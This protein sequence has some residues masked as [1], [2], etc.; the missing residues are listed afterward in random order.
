MFSLEKFDKLSRAPIT[1]KTVSLE[2]IGG[3]G[4][5]ISSW[6]GLLSKMDKHMQY[7][8][9]TRV[10]GELIIADVEESVRFGILEKVVPYVERLIANMQLDYVSNP[11][12]PACEQKMCIEEVRSLYFLL[13]LSYQSIAF[14]LHKILTHEASLLPPKNI[15]WLKKMTGG[16]SAN[17]AR[18]GVGVDLVSESKKLYTLSVYRIM[19]SCYRL[20]SEFALTYQKS[21]ISLWR[22]MN[23]WYLKSAALELDKFNISKLGDYADC[24]IHKQYLY[25]CLASFA[26]LFAYRRADI[27]N[28]FKLVPQWSDCVETSF[29]AESHHRL[30][31]NLQSDT[32]PE[33]ITPFASVNPYSD[34]RVCLFFDVRKLFGYL[35]NLET[36][37]ETKHSFEGRLAK[38]ILLAFNRQFEQSDSKPTDRSAYMMTGFGAIYKEIAGGR[39]FNQI[40][41]QSKL[42]S[43]YHP[44]RVFDGQLSAEKE[45]VQLIR[46]NESVTQFIVGGFAN[47]NENQIA[48]RPYLPVFGVFAMMSPRSDNKHPWRLGIVHWA[49][50]NNN[51]VEVD[52]R[53]LGRILSV[54]GIRLNSRDGRG[55]DFV[56]A[57]LVSGDELDE[58]TT[59]VLP[60][61]HFKEGDVVVLRVEDKETTLRLEKAVLA[62]DNLEQ[63]QIVRLS[64]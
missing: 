37:D 32:A 64:A 56:Q 17:I 35:N 51:H 24:S 46:R 41:A 15:S 14:A 21:P 63:Y 52:G 57:F 42:H 43:D 55:Q 45:L 58:Q 11:K 9:T 40:I 34:E 19:V 44:K 48:S 10:L 61:Y 22:L 39:S 5:K 23:G 33:M 50:P 12:C 3:S 29:E 2:A 20:M 62:T 27:I 26:N 6:L 53:F 8:E 28:I 7:R 16:L 13:I 4:E 38:I 36:N 31:V 47:Q 60:R 59:L 54:C 1:R 49:S 18:N 30:F 25:S